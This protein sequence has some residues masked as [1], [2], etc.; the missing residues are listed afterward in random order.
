MFEILVENRQGDFITWDL[1]HT[2]EQAEQVATQLHKQKKNTR[3]VD[4]DYKKPPKEDRFH[5]GRRD[6]DNEE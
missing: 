4:R 3:I 2:R 1:R 5:R 6:R